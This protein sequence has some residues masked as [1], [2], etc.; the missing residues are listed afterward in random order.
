MISNRPENEIGA[1]S[2]HKVLRCIIL[3]FK[4]VK[5]ELYLLLRLLDTYPMGF[6]PY[7]PCQLFFIIS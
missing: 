5:Y 7:Q 4:K 3:K 2:F 6:V 1:I